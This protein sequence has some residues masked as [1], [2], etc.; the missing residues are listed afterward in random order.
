[1]RE[2]AR[3]LDP[4]AHLR[5]VERVEF[6]AERDLLGFAYL[7][8]DFAASRSERGRSDKDIVEAGRQISGKSAIVLGPHAEV[9]R[10][11]DIRSES[12]TISGTVPVDQYHCTGQWG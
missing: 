12:G 8:A 5:C 6:Q 10:C 9:R 2:T 1:M 7:H 4:V 3:R 11:P